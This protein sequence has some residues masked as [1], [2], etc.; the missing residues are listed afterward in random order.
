VGRRVG[1]RPS[2]LPKGDGALARGGG[3][4][5]KARA[6]KTFFVGPLRSEKYPLHFKIPLFLAY[7]SFPI[8]YGLEGEGIQLMARISLKKSKYYKH[9]TCHPNKK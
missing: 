3:Y 9:T 6:K 1:R 8:H 4:S 7:G 5:E 2:L